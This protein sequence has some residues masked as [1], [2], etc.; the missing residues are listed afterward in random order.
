MAK[1][2]GALSALIAD[3]KESLG[4]V[5]PKIVAPILSILARI[6]ARV[7]FIHRKSL[8]LC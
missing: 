1:V 4:K 7:W 5:Y 2:R 8:E 6:S 3:F